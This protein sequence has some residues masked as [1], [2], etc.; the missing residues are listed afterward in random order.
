MAEQTLKLTADEALVLFEWLSL[1]E[2]DV[3]AADRDMNADDIVFARMLGQLEQ[4]L[5]EPFAGNYAALLDAARA[6]IVG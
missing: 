6:R 1:R 3:V 4:T 2:K 5:V